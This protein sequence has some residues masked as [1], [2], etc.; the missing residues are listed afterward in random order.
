MK[1]WLVISSFRNDDAVLNLI[2]QAH[3]SAAGLFE[4][5]LVVD[6]QGTGRV[7]QVIRERGWQDV[8]YRC[9]DENLGSGANLAERLKAAASAGADYAY[10]VN[11]DGEID[12]DVIGKL[13]AA[14][15][16]RKNLGAA[17]PLGYFIETGRYNLTGTRELPLPAKLVKARPQEPIIPVYWSSSNGALYSLQPVREGVVPW[18]A[19]W[20]GW[21]DLEYGWQLYDH[22][23]EQIIVTS[24]LY[25]D[26]QEYDSSAVGKVTRKPYWRTYY[27]SRNLVLAVRRCRNTPLYHAVVAFRIVR[28]LALTL[29]VRD[30]KMKRLRLLLAGAR[31]GYRGIEKMVAVA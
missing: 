25:R 1:T 17:Y 14:A 30:E 9:F 19:M 18:A 10:A 11:H 13:L 20:M 2:E 6:S 12:P 29:L 21:E 24:A 3:S 4:R 5:I 26:N 23:Y 28:E 22:G 27:N 15:Q 16:E 7:P 31:D 8:E